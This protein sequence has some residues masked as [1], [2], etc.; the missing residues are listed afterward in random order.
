MMLSR[1]RWKVGIHFED[2]PIQ[3]EVI[4]QHCSNVKVVL[5]EHDLVNKENVRRDGFGK[6]IT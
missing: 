6:E 3:A 1:Y 4:K 2:D 5:L